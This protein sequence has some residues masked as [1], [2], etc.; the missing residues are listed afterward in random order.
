MV[1]E[2]VLSVDLHEP[3]T[4]FDHPPGDQA[5]GPVVGRGWFVD[6]VEFLGGL[7]LFCDVEGSWAEVCILEASW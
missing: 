3:N 2:L 1:P 5:A 6:A 4:S 7:G